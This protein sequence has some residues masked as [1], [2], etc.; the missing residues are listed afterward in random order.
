MRQ[1]AEFAAVLACSLFTG[2]AV[3]ISLV[4]H[5]ARME[6]GVELAATEFRP[7]YRRATV[8]Q[9]SLAAVGLVSSIAAWLAGATFWWLVAGALLGSVI[10]FTLFVILPTNK[11]LLSPTLDRR[12]VE[13]ERLL[14]RWGALHAVRSVLSGV[15][16]L[17]FLYLTIFKKPL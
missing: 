6:C 15:A 5:P 3:Y 2:A 14:A 1:I 12:S 17:L 7:S 13:A 10:P 4:E 16:L 8:M 11:L 9:A